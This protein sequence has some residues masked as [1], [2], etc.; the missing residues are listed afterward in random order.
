MVEYAH[1]MGNSLGAFKEY[2]DKIYQYGVT[3]TAEILPESSFWSPLCVKHNDPIGK[4]PYTIVK[5][6]IDF[7]WKKKLQLTRPPTC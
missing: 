4:S 6:L 2:W 1:A 7:E 3:S 5:T